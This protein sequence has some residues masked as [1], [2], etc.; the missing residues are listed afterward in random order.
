MDRTADQ[1]RTADGSAAPFG[2][3]P[4]AGTAVQ[5]RGYGPDPDG[6]APTAPQAPA[7]HG[8]PGSHP[9]Q[10][11][12]GGSPYGPSPYGPQGAQ[13][14]DPWATPGGPTPPGGGDGGSGGDGGG[15]RGPRRRP[16]WAGVAGVAVAG[17]VAASALTAGLLG[18]FG[19]EAGTGTTVS[20]RSGGT[21][22]GVS[23]TTVNWQAVADSVSPS[24]VA[25]GVSSAQGSGVGSG[26]VYDEQGHV[27]TNNHV[28]T[29][30]GANAQIVVTLSDGRRYEAT[31]VGT[32]P[33]T[34][35]AVLQLQDP[36][37]DLAPATFA[38]SDEVVPGQAVMALGNPLGLAGSATTGIV[39][40]VDRPVLT[41]AET[42]AQNPYGGPFGQQTTTE[43][44]ATNAIQTDAAINPGNSG[45][46]LLDSS[47]R[48]IG[49]NSS[50]ATLSS[51]ASAQ[52]GSIGLG[53]AIP[54]NEVGMI[55][56]QLVADG[57]ADHA[58]LGVSLTQDDPAVTVGEV[59]RTGAQVAA[60]SEGTPAAQAGLR[61]GD[62]ITAV[63]G[64]FTAGYEALTAAVRE[65]A[66]G[67]EV[68]LT[69]VRDGSE[70]TLTA[71]L[72][73]RPES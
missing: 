3:S 27:V 57:T 16:G 62:V 49:V 5:A 20:A 8:Y 23:E 70:E 29:G 18:A 13:P 55:A 46:A 14:H 25:V 11:L 17:A 12:R 59:T 47:G 1:H 61:A 9:T 31:I 56:D 32:D 7:Q 34:D 37:A 58:W 45:G 22:Q 43:T 50:I 21:I 68:E 10:P 26:I 24:V 39:S 66:V 48:V 4:S 73:A 69:V 53:F 38:D 44:V 64:E 60:V 36:P 28:V 52:S 42:E 30:A 65:V 63:D 72:T 33:A 15:G 54:A 35:L 6:G 19:Q 41:T 71:T 51:S 40:A 2:G 67:S